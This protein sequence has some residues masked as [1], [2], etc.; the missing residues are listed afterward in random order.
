MEIPSPV[1]SCYSLPPFVYIFVTTVKK[2]W[3][4]HEN[5]VEVG[6]A[7]GQSGLVARTL[8]L[9]LRENWWEAKRQ[10]NLEV[11]SSPS[12]VLRLSHDNK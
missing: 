4:F 3:L 8:V 7:G 10:N 12:Q 1:V 2:K 11:V 9:V 5:Q 6:G